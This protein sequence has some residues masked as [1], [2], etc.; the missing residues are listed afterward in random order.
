VLVGWCTTT[1]GWLYAR[2]AV[3]PVKPVI[4]E[5]GLSKSPLPSC[6][7]SI[8]R[9]AVRWEAH[10]SDIKVSCPTNLLPINGLNMSE[11]HVWAGHTLLVQTFVHHQFGWTKI[12]SIVGK[13]PNRLAAQRLLG[14]TMYEVQVR[15]WYGKADT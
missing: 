4:F 12:P 14:H 5:G 1:V 8:D 11:G 6:R 7:L 9:C 13:S 10:G 15:G 3:R 2:S